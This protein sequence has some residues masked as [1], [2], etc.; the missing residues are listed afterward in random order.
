LRLCE[1][2][3]AELWNVQKQ[4]VLEWL[5]GLKTKSNVLTV[6]VNIHNLPEDTTETICLKDKHVHNLNTHVVKMLTNQFLTDVT[7]KVKDKEFKAHKVVLAAASPVFEAMFKE[8][9]KE[10]E[11]NYVNIEDMDSDVFEVFLR[12]LYSGQVDKLAEMFTDLF[13]AADKYDVQLLR[14]IC[15]QQMVKNISVD[16]AV[17]MLALADRYDVE[18]VKIQAQNLITNNI[19]DVMKTDSWAS[20]LGI[21]FKVAKEIDEDG[22]LRK[23]I[24][25]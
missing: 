7:L 14:E 10:R 16:N 18:P 9:T 15:M 8:G 1:G 22:P 17:E 23:K 6:F 5:N 24:K 2:Q 20:I 3:A 25:K 4:K 19:A 13:T 12:Y 11:D 21:Y